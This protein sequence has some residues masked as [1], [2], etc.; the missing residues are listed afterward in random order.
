MAGRI[1]GVLCLFS[2]GYGIFSGQGDALA[3]AI[4]DGAESAVELVLFLCGTMALWNGVLAVLRMAGAIKGLSR[5][6]SPLLRVIFPR[7]SEDSEGRE[8]RE[9]ISCCF[10]ANLLGIGNAAT[11]FALSALEKM[12][13]SNRDPERPTPEMVSLT[14]LNTAPFCIL[15]ATILALRGEAGSSS[16]FSVL[17]PICIASFGTAVF[18]LL[19]TGIAGR[20]EER[21]QRGARVRA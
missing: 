2:V 4:F 5:L 18:G 11:P 6:L 13:K 10:A 19:L 16:P 3:G 1:F 12:Q 15:P 8:I 14:V 20:I 9:D 21:T 7:L 17:L